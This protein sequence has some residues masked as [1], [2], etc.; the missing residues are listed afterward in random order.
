M[1][2]LYSTLCE[3][4]IPTSARKHPNQITSLCK[5]DQYFVRRA[6]NAM[7]HPLSREDTSCMHMGASY[8][9]PHIV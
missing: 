9:A 7:G 2:D 6:G 4:I 1:R 5:Q 3:V 8:G